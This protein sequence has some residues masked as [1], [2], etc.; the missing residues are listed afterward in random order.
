MS[1]LQGR[2]RLR[3]P[4]YAQLDQCLED[5]TQG[6]GYAKAD[7]RTKDESGSKSAAEKCCF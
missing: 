1:G 7:G 6:R 3:V 4:A 2:A 5:L